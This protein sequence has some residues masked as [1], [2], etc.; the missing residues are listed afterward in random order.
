MRYLLLIPI[1]IALCLT[2]RHKTTYVTN[3]VY[4]YRVVPDQAFSK[5]NLIVMLK[6]MNVKHYRVAYAQAVV[7]TGNFTSRMFRLNNNLFGMKEATMRVNLARGT[8]YGH[9]YYNNWEESVTDYALWVAAY[10]NRCRTK[11]QMYQLLEGYYAEDPNY[12]SKLKSIK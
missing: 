11:E 6:E 8:Q 2:P 3:K 12:I 1:C 7:E 10:A 4:V 9:A 5:A